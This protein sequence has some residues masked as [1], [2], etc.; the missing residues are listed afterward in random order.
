MKEVTEVVD[1]RGRKM[2]IVGNLNCRTVGAVYAMWCRKCEKV[3][4]VGKTMNRVMERFNSHRADLKGGDPCKPAYHFK[5]EGHEEGDMGV[6][7]LEEVAGKDDMYR[8]TRER[9]WM[10][11]LGTFQEENKKK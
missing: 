9:W 4:Y 1:K 7:V 2:R 6:I 8:V 10:N 5:K 11:C 3:V